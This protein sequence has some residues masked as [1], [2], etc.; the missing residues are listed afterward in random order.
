MLLAFV[1]QE[2]NLAV[3]LYCSK[4]RYLDDVRTTG[5]RLGSECRMKFNL[6]WC[7]KF[8]AVSQIFHAHCYVNS[9]LSK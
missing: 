6:N 5:S 3:C 8:P 7:I 1:S 2:G 4:F 9:K